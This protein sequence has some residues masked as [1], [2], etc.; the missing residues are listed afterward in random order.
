MQTKTCRFLLLGLGLMAAV[1]CSST[2]TNVSKTPDDYVKDAMAAQKRGYYDEA[3]TNW[4]KVKESYASPEL[5]AL[6]E[7]TIADLYFDKES[8]IEA[9]VAYEDF[10]KL[11]PTHEKAPYAAYRQALSQYEQI[12]GIDTDQTPTNNALILFEAFLRQYPQ[13]DLA[14]DAKAKVDSCR[15]K[16][17][18][19]ELYVGKFYLKTDKLQ[20]AIKRLEDAGKSF[21]IIVGTD[22]LLF[23]LGKAYTLNGDKVKAQ[24]VFARLLDE[25]ASSSFSA[26]AKTFMAKNK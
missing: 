13:S 14:A 26:E 16:L 20:A 7:I 2:N 4:K 22:E 3:I 12:T 5:T 15:S 18:Q 19:R 11:H 24:A 23:Y 21:P 1:G 25:Y 8:Y 9:A 17:F 6:A 10:R